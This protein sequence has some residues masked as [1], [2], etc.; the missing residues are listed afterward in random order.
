[1]TRRG[2]K[3]L[4]TT[5]QADG[6]RRSKPGLSST[7]RT[8]RSWLVARSTSEPN[9]WEMVRATNLHITSNDSSL[10]NKKVLLRG[11]LSSAD[12]MCAVRTPLLARKR[13]V[14]AKTRIKP[15]AHRNQLTRCFN[16]SSFVVGVTATPSKRQRAPDLVCVHESRGKGFRD[17]LLLSFPR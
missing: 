15:E 5:S 10:H 8:D 9:C 17:R 2:G 11:A 14:T 7:R 1:M 12:H 4:R 3:K 13:C 6:T 16:V